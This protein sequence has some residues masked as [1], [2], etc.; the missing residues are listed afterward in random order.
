VSLLSGIALGY[1][2]KDHTLLSPRT[3]VTAIPSLTFR[4]NPIEIAYVTRSLTSNGIIGAAL[5]GL[6]LWFNFNAKK[7]FKLHNTPTHHGEKINSL[8]TSGVFSISRY[9]LILT[10]LLEI[11]VIVL[12]ILSLYSNEI[13]L[14]FL[15][16]V[17]TN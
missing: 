7:Q 8:I 13:S 12:Y 10:C 4:Q 9:S 3:I 1:Y 2:F 17:F 5:I 6:G 16:I 15:E 14:I 11:L